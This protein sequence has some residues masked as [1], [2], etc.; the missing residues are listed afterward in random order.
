MLCRRF[1]DALL[2]QDQAAS[3]GGERTEDVNAAWAELAPLYW[4]KRVPPRGPAASIRA[5]VAENI[6]G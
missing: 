1:C 5:R 3:V 2:R 6:H 4:G